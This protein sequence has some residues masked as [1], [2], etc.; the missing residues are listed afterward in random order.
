MTREEFYR[1]VYDETVSRLSDCYKKD[2]IVLRKQTEMGRTVMMLMFIKEGSPF[3][4]SFNLDEY[5]EEYLIMMPQ[6]EYISEIEK[7]GRH[8]VTDLERY[9]SLNLDRFENVIDKI[10]IRLSALKNEEPDTLLH[11]IKFDHFIAEFRINLNSDDR[12]SYCPPVF[13]KQ[14]R[15]WFITD[16]ILLNAAYM[17]QMKEGIILSPLDEAKISDGFQLKKNYWIDPPAQEE[18]RAAGLLV[19]TNPAGSFGASLILNQAV[20]QRIY[21]ILGV[22]YYILPSSVHEVM[23]L[24]DNGNYD[25]E[26]ISDLVRRVN[27]SEVLA[28]DVLADEVFFY[29][30]AKDRMITGREHAKEKMCAFGKAQE[31]LMAGQL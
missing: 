19:L 15:D 16:E 2:E 9:R 5:Y 18:A 23:I 11:T 3:S 7:V 31:M 17:N 20:L 24:A 14:F 10:S 29:D 1:T 13:E 21:W 8:H 4:P 12:E 30:A 27:E 6:E 25:A 28:M 26:K 22:N